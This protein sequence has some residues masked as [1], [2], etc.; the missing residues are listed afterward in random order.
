MTP[1]IIDRFA[2]P[3]GW[4]EGLRMIGRTDVIGIEWDASA[5]ET[6][7]ANGH[8][9]VQAD[10]ALLDPEDFVAEHLAGVAP[11]GGIDS[12]PCQGF[13]AAGKGLGRGDTP[14]VLS[15]VARIGAGE[16]VDLVLK[17]LCAQCADP[18]T[19][20]VLEP[21]R[22]ALALRPAWLAW[23]QV[24]AVLPLWEACAEILRG[25]GWSVWTGMLQA[26]QYGVPQT[27]KRAVLTAS[28]HRAVG[29]PVPTHS[30]FHVRDRTRLDPGVL[31]W[32]SMAQAL[33]SGMTGRP[34]M[35]DTGGGSATG[36]AEPFGNA[37]RQG[38]LRELGAGRWAMGDVRAANGT[39]RAIDE[40][41]AALT[42]SMD[43]G[44]FA[45]R[46]RSNSEDGASTRVTIEQ[47]AIL[48]S[49]PPDYVWCGT[50]SAQYQQVGNAV[51]PLLAAHIL[52][53]VGADGRPPWVP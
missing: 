26:E 3:G 50:K 22:W 14:H 43:N 13:S 24:P 25:A 33:G 17:E 5:C 21:L 15:A 45:W 7:R 8:A 18:R 31:P 2:G 9:R 48:Q 23:E 52:W 29:R 41:S 42:A 40:P 47:A 46:L 28:R 44:N 6:A 35:T 36:G 1:R 11:E 51:P 10:V 27:R 12:P 34:S 20:L 38:M 39:V 4:D 19:A 37:A 53:S 49:F 16:R 30:R 32:V